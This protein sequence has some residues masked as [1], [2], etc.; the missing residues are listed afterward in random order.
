[1]HVSSRD[2]YIFSS[3]QEPEA[4][5][6]TPNE[7][8]QPHGQEGYDFSNIQRSVGTH[9]SMT[10]SYLQKTK[11]HSDA[12]EQKCADFFGKYAE[13]GTLLNEFKKK[14]ELDESVDLPV[15]FRHLRELVGDYKQLEISE[16]RPLTIIVGE[17]VDESA[18]E[19]IGVFNQILKL[20]DEF[21]TDH[22]AAERFIRD[23]RQLMQGEGVQ[24]QST[25]EA[26]ERSEQQLK[27]I[28]Q[29]S[30][31]IKNLNSDVNVAKASLES[32]KCVTGII[33]VNK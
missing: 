14:L 27:N 13:I 7:L 22:A 6:E 24:T 19:A 30:Q 29:L 11:S 12:V 17:Y 15:C 20:C 4:A 10:E 16:G 23:K 9:V 25:L 28:E 31:Q 8:P 26:Q 3:W 1:M 18:M 21:P 32:R 2:V 5:G 33:Q